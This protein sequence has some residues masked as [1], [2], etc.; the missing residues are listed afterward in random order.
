MVEGSYTLHIVW[1]ISEA[2]TQNQE[3]SQGNTKFL[4]KSQINYLCGPHRIRH[5]FPL[6]EQ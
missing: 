1:H 4:L 3:W 2:L 5:L 6:N